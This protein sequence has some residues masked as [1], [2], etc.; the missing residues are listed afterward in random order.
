MIDFNIE[1]NDM[2]SIWFTMMFKRIWSWK[3]RLYKVP[4]LY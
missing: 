4:L 3:F 2:I 1:K